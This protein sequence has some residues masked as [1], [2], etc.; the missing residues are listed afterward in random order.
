M[1]KLLKIFFTTL[2]I[3][4]CSSDVSSEDILSDNNENEGSGSFS[5]GG[6]QTNPELIVELISTYNNQ[7]ASFATQFGGYMR[8]FIVHTPPNFDYQT[9]SLPLL[10]FSIKFLVTFEYAY[11]L[12][13][14]TLVD[15]TFTSSFKIIPSSRI[16]SII[17]LSL[18]ST[19]NS[20]DIYPTCDILIMMESR[21]VFI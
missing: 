19:L 1:N 4:H 10:F 9:E 3:I 12:F 7:T 11:G 20:F 17:F 8:N 5:G 21:P 18:T 6:N 2:F 14:L 13:L 15:V 16:N